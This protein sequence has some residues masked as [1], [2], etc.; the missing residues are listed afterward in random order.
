MY[1]VIIAGMNFWQN[2]PKPIIGLSPM[3]GFTDYPFRKIVKTYGNPE[4]IFTEFVHV[5]GLWLGKIKVFDHLLFDEVQKPIVAQVFGNEPDFF[6][7]A[8][9][10]ICELGFDGIDI[11]MGC[12]ANS[13]VNRGGGGSLITNPVLAKEILMKTKKGVN[14]WTCG[15]SLNDLGLSKDKIKLIK[16]RKIRKDNNLKSIPVSVKTR[17]GYCE[18]NIIEWVGNLIEAKPDVITVHGRT[19]KQL[20]GGKA[21]WE[22]IGSAALAVKEKG[23]IYLGNGDVKDIYDAK[24]KCGTYGLDG[25]LI[26]RAALGNPWVFSGK[27]AVYKEKLTVCLKQAKLFD[28]FYKGKYFYAFRKHFGF[29]CKGF[30]EAKNLRI[31]LMKCE[32]YKQAQDLISK[33]L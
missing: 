15:Q 5:K 12:P 14:D 2:I 3:D 8:A 33:F 4:V 17:I 29:Y 18:N 16:D 10:I 27:N 19:L 7:K 25:V 6:Y 31:D 26:G 32:S 1:L 21:D 11:N 22:A 9:H 30:E 28:D 24:E 23:I 13:V 20:Y